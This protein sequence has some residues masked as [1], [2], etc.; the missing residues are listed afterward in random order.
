MRILLHSNGPRV[1]LISWCD[2]KVAARGLCDGHYRRWQKG[3][4]L[5]APWGPSRKRNGPKPVRFCSVDWCDRLLYAKRLCREHYRRQSEGRPLDAPWRRRR[6]RRVTPDGYVELA[7]PDHPR[8]R[9][10]GYVAE[11]RLVMEAALGRYLEQWENVHHKNGVR[12]DNRI[13]NLELWV[14]PQPSGQRAEDLARWV[15]EHY[16]ELVREAVTL[17]AVV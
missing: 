3:A 12:D 14:R 8:A 15:A 10:F 6:E 11:H 7:R 16:P 5:E 13:E 1:C 2:A 4:D 17:K 9:R